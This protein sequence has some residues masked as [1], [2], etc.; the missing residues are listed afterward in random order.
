MRSRDRSGW[1][2]AATTTT[3]TTTTVVSDFALHRRTRCTADAAD[4]RRFYT[5]TRVRK[6]TLWRTRTRSLARLAIIAGEILRT[7]VVV[8]VVDACAIRSL[9]CNLR[10]NAMQCDV[11]SFHI[12]DSFT[13]QEP[14]AA[15]RQPAHQQ[16]IPIYINAYGRLSTRAL[17]ICVAATDTRICTRAFSAAGAVQR[18]WFLCVTPRTRTIYA[19]INC[20]PALKTATRRV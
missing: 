1:F 5:Q 8:V 16:G 20:C 14:T 11:K 2:A 3:T 12:I 6:R 10:C 15:D 13:Q 7:G 9:H 19:C 18:V 4:D 17:I